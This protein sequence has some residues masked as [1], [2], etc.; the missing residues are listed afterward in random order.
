MSTASK[1]LARVGPQGEG[2]AVCAPTNSEDKKSV[3]LLLRAPNATH[4]QDCWSW[5]AKFAQIL[6]PLSS[7]PTFQLLIAL[8]KSLS[9]VRWCGGVCGLPPQ[10]C[11]KNG[12][13]LMKGK[14]SDYDRLRTTSGEK[15]KRHGK[16][17]YR[18]LSP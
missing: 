2:R 3:Q 7:P 11:V 9:V 6:R 10:T 5:L 8:S 13:S 18:N 17:N 1:D 14:I 15:P 4:L 16:R 12:L